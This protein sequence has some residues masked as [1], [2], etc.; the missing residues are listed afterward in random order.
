VAGRPHP[1]LVVFP[2]SAR[3]SC[4]LVLAARQNNL[5]GN[6]GLESKVR[7]TETVSSTRETR[8]LPDQFALSRKEVSAK[9]ARSGSA[10]L[11]KILS[12]FCA[13]LVSRRA[14]ARDAS[15]PMTAG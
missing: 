14:S 3:V 7:E 1:P 10:S 8:A 9:R 6:T 11:P 13:A 15:S 2:G 12:A 5:S 4:V